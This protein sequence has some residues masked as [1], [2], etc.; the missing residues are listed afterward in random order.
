M[1]GAILTSAAQI[2]G[3]SSPELDMEVRS[4]VEDVRKQCSWKAMQLESN[5]VGKQCSWKAM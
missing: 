2:Q 1:E 4:E 3:E 5:V